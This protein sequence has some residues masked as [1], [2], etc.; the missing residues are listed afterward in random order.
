MR[1]NVHAPT[2]GPVLVHSLG[3]AG[4]RHRGMA[5][6]PASRAGRWRVAAGLQL[7]NL[8]REGGRLGLR[9][10]AVVQGERED[11]ERLT[12]EG[13]NIDYWI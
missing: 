4:Y 12:T 2:H 5:W 8:Q 13:S 11:V 7:A 3:Q 1:E 6:H 10:A 9:G